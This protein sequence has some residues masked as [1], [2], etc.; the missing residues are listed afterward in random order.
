MTATL[1]LHTAIRDLRAD[2]AMY[3]TFREKGRAA[4][5]SLGIYHAGMAQATMYAIEKLERLATSS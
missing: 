4:G 1:G 2:L 3:E 5:S